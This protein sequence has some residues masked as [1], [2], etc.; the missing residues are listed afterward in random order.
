MAELTTIARSD[1]N[2][3]VSA[4]LISIPEA[5]ALIGLHVDTLRRLCRTGQF[6]PALQIGR[7]W[8]V[9]VPRLQRYLHGET[10][11]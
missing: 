7:Q 5:A 9:S 2:Q 6:P 10:A 4:D 1:Q 8:R 3:R 11:S